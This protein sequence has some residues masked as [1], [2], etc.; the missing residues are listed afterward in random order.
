VDYALRG[1]VSLALSAAPRTK[2]D[3]LATDHGLSRKFLAQVLVELRDAGLVLTQRGSDGGY[4]LA[5]P[6]EQIHVVEIFEAVAPGRDYKPRLPEE[7]QAATVTAEAWS[8][9]A[10]ATRD[11][12]ARITLADLLAAPERDDR[13]AGG[14]AIEPSVSG[15]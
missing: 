10:G 3:V 5:R 11:L 14:L 13:T 9:L 12:L 8:A 2:I 4:A 15:G 6:P 1:L 7:S